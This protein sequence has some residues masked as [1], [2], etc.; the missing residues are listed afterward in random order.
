MKIFPATILCWEKTYGA[1][2]VTAQIV[3]AKHR[4]I[5]EIAQT[6]ACEI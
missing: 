3:P 5:R 2:Q 1:R 4:L 6:K